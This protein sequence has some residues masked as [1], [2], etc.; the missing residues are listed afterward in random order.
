MWSMS[1]ALPVIVH[2]KEGNACLD[3]VSRMLCVS[4][5]RDAERFDLET[6]NWEKLERHLHKFIILIFLTSVLQEC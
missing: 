6:V 4:C 1:A 2:L 3:S 5:R